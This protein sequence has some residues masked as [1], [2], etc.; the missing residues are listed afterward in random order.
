MRQRRGFV[1]ATGVLTTPHR[2]ARGPGRVRVRRWGA[3]RTTTPSA[4]RG[5]ARRTARSSRESR[6]RR[7]GHARHG[8]RIAGAYTVPRTRSERMPSARTGG[9]S[10]HARGAR[11]R[12]APRAPKGMGRAVQG[13]AADR[14]PP[15]RASRSARSNA[16]RP[17]KHRSYGLS[18]PVGAARNRSREPTSASACQPCLSDC[19]GRTTPA[20][21][22]RARPH[23]AR[24][25][26]G[27]RCRATDARRRGNGS[28]ARRGSSRP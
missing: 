11:V 5:P 27:A 7:M 22:G 25:G 23:P 28:V 4:R 10:P 24:A 14:S 21:A 2:A 8:A 17:R 13:P 20:A 15:R 9:Y 6:P 19:A 16:E 26:T 12:R 3:R 18:Y 1:R